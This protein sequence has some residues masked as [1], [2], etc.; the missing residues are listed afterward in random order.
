MCGS[1]LYFRGG[2]TL[3]SGE[4]LVS[5]GRSVFEGR[6]GRGEGCHYEVFTSS[7]QKFKISFRIY[8]QVVPSNFFRNNFFS[9]T[10]SQKT[11]YEGKSKCLHNFLICHLPGRE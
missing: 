9:E 3:C 4:I 2:Y 7:V 6:C 8:Q 1:S 10:Y 11:C 5:K